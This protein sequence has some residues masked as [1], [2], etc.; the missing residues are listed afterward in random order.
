MFSIL[1]FNIPVIFD[2]IL[3]CIASYGLV[4]V[5]A[6]DLGIHTGIK[7][8]KLTQKP[9]NQF[10]LLYSGAYTVARE[11]SLAIFSTITYYVL[12]YVYS[13]GKTEEHRIIY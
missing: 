10:L 4:Q 12:K 1:D 13:E 9:I 8:R 3:V 11:H 5:L 2:K 7:Q 6:Q